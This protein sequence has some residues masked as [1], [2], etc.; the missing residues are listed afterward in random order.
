MRCDC[1]KKLIVMYFDMMFF[2]FQQHNFYW[3]SLGLYLS[4]FPSKKCS[5]VLWGPT[6]QKVYFNCPSLK[7]VNTLVHH[8]VL[9]NAHNFWCLIMGFCDNYV[10]WITGIHRFSILGLFTL[11]EIKLYYL[12]ILGLLH[13]FSIYWK[14]L[15]NLKYLLWPT[16]FSPNFNG[17]ISPNL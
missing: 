16:V 13:Q 3:D 12:C 17:D 4:F 2:F 1:K 5:L 6:F 11:S 15:H 9:L 7:S 14:C 10:A 8:S